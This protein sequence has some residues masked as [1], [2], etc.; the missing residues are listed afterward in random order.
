MVF[1]SYFLQQRY[2]NFWRSYQYG[3]LPRPL[4]IKWHHTTMTSSWEADY[5]PMGWTTK[6]KK[7]GFFGVTPRSFCIELPT[8]RIQSLEPKSR[9]KSEDGGSKFL[10]NLNAN[11]PNQTVTWMFNTV[12]ISNLITTKTFKPDVSWASTKVTLSPNLI[13]TWHWILRLLESGRNS[14]RPRNETHYG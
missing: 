3:G 14:W 7:T 5:I 11:Q 2:M 12:R 4:W 9:Q 8:F 6:V 13:I 1:D 10:R